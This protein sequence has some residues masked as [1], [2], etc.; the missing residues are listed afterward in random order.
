MTKEQQLKK[1]KQSD[2][3]MKPTQYRQYVDFVNE[4]SGGMCQNSQ[5]ENTAQDIHHS[6]FGAGGRDDRYITAICRHCHSMIHC[7]VDTDKAKRLKLAFK[8]I[9]K[10]NWIEYNG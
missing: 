9:G 8:T 5:C 4:I 3:K 6:Y 2:K 1:V 10:Q 7:G